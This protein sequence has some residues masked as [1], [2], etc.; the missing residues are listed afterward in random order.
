MYDIF[1]QDRYGYYLSSDKKKFYN[2]LECIL[3]CESHNLEFS[4]NFND[5]HYDLTNWLKEPT[6]NIADFY[7]DR[8]R[9]LRQKYDYLV[10]HL[11]GGHDSGNILELFI[12]NDIRLDEVITRGPYEGTNPDPNDRSAKNTFA[13]VELCAVPLAK[14]AKEQYQPDLRITVIET[15]QSTVDLWRQD[16]NWFELGYNDLDPGQLFRGEPHLIEPRYKQMTDQGKT[17]AHIY[18]TDK[19]MFY[20]RGRQ[21]FLVFRDD[22]VNRFNP[23]R[24]SIND[25][26][27]IEHFY[28]GPSTGGLLAKQAHLILNKLNCLDKPMDMAIKLMNHRGPQRFIQDWKASI[29]YPNR[30]LPIWDTE[31][32]THNV[33]RD[34]HHWFWTETNSDFFHTWKKHMDH[35]NQVVPKKYLRNSDI[36]HGY[37]PAWSKGYLIGN[38]KHDNIT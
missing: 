20:L 31:K 29:I 7:V 16:K 15:K 2:K 14:I 25:I 17:V 18:G 10:L 33:F 6:R 11:S 37:K 9:E 4:W 30:F 34:W 21:L 26:S 35:L 28:W 23:F 38:I 12:T 19:P 24:N 13:E 32:S 1:D 8:A 3:H 27:F 36:Y 5:Q 22:F